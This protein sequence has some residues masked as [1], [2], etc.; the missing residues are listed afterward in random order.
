MS[1]GNVFRHLHGKLELNDIFWVS[2]SDKYT[3]RNFIFKQQSVTK[4]MEKTDIWTIL[5]FS[6]LLP[7]NNVEEQWAKLVSSNVIG[8]QHCVGGEGKF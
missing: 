7:L 5:C 6:P 8:L 4:I 2:S 3:N 1:G